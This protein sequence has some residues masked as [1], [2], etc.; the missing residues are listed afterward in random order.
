M[1]WLEAFILAIIEG[2]TEFLPVSS[3]GHMILASSLMGIAAH[4]FTKLFTIAIQFGA[5]LAVVVEYRKKLLTVNKQRWITILVAFIPA[6]IIGKLLDDFIDSLL[7]NP[8]VV[9]ITLLLGGLIL[10]WIDT[11]LSGRSL[12]DKEPN[13][14]QSFWIGCFQCIAMIPGVSRSAAT[15]I[16]GLIQGLSRT[17]AAEFSFFVA[18]PTM[19]AATSHKLFK[20]LKSGAHFQSEEIHLLLLGNVVAFVVAWLAIRSFIHFLNKNGFK[21]FGY[22]RVILGLIILFI[23]YVLQR[24]LQ[25]I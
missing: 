24:P 13:R 7:E 1:N 6:A 2:I 3:T 15:I 22:Y 10:I 23:L 19:F 11:W 25:I 9:A 21:L 14:L 20:Y 8:T 4:P 16:G 17:S 5:I 18:I 12:N